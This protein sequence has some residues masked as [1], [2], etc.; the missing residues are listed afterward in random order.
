VG[1]SSYKRRSWAGSGHGIKVTA[2]GDLF[3]ITTGEG[4]S[5][6]ARDG[7]WIARGPHF[8]TAVLLEDL[9]GQVT[10]WNYSKT[11]EVGGVPLQRYL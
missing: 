8:T 3:Y 11:F 7:V 4:C 5:I 10:G 1:Q 6:G 2:N 9:T